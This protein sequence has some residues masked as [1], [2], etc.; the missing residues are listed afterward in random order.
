MKTHEQVR[1]EMAACNALLDE[2]PLAQRD[3]AWIRGWL[4]GV[5]AARMSIFVAKNRAGP[6]NLP[7]FLRG[8]IRAGRYR[9]RRTHRPLS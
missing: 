8:F 5:H 4:S 2:F 9:S 6:I 7:E 3:S 1:K